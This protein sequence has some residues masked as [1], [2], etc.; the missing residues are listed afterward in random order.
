M[1]RE[2]LKESFEG[3]KEWVLDLKRNEFLFDASFTLIAN[4]CDLESARL[5]TYNEGKEYADS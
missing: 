1:Y 3:A 4:K 5:V 2:L